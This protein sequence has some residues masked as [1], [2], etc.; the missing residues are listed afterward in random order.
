M[1]KIIC[2]VACLC[3]GT[4]NAAVINSI[5]DNATSHAFT[6]IDG[7]TDGPISENGYT[8]T[9]DNSSSV[10]GYEGGYALDQ[11]GRWGSGLTFIGLNSQT[12]SMTFDFDNSVSSVTAFLNYATTSYGFGLIS[13]YDAANN[14]L[15]SH[16]LDINTGSSSY[17]D[18]EYW[19]FSRQ[20]ADISSFVIS[21]A[22]IVAADLRTSIVSTSVPA[23]A[24]IALLGL[25][26]A[27]IGFSRKN[28]KA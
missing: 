14:L 3:A 25:G 1:K 22:Y 20:T 15:E 21:N 8:W 18:G 13:I 23:P 12:G 7:L 26:L 9:S 24:S 4:A 10:Y 6:P 28:K 16:E 2:L 11:N 17:N 5:S 27:G 19:G